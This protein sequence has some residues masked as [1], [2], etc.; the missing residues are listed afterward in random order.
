MHTFQCSNNATKEL[1]CQ[2]FDFVVS[3][4]NHFLTLI[5]DLKALKL[6]FTS[7]TR[8]LHESNTEG[9]CT[10]SKRSPTSNIKV[11]FVE[12]QISPGSHLCLMTQYQ[13]LHLQ[14]HTGTII[15]SVVHNT[16]AT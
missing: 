4:Q 2:R 6:E 1:S 8:M 16:A 14:Q 15:N 3:T 12:K 5:H 11:F 13:C 7:C 10:Q 9:A